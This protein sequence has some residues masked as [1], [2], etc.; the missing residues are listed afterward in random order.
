MVKG[1]EQKRGVAREARFSKSRLAKEITIAGKLAGRGPAENIRLRSG[2]PGTNRSVSCMLRKKGQITVQRGAINDERLVRV[3]LEA[4]ADEL[5]TEEEQYLIFTSHDQLYA[6]AEALKHVGVMTSG[7]KF[8]FIPDTTVPVVDEAK[9]I[10][11]LRFCE[12]L[13]DDDD[14][15]SVYSI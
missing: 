5:T 14:V 4:G 15:Q 2:N 8:T 9:A 12:S 10:Q 13:E 1:N 7:Q 11:V 3:A 6:A